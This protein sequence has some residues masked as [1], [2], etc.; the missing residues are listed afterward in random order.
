LP[1]AIDYKFLSDR[2]G[3][4]RTK[5]Y[6]PDP[7]N[8]QSGV[9]VATGFDL[10]ARSEIDLNR[11]GLGATLVTKLK[12]YL[13]K[14]KKDA[15][16]TLKQAPLTITLAEAQQ[17]DKASFASHVSDIKRAYDAAV[18]ADK[19]KKKFEDLPSEAQ[20][21]I[22]SLAFQYGS[23]SSETPKFWKAAVSQDWKETLKILRNFD[24]PYPTRRNLEAD[25]LQKIVP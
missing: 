11:L 15:V 24:D 7:V 16:D 2:E 13:G 6:V 1:D 19:T 10:G 14:K 4:Q 17:I 12:P 21:V 8:S 9:T 18:G 3:G 22:A 23:L 5:A 25:V 20:T